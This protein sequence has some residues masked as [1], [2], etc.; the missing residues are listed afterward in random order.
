MGGDIHIIW[1]L[2]CFCGQIQFHYVVLSL[3]TDQMPSLSVALPSRTDQ[4][5]SPS[6]VLP[7]RT[8]H[9][10][11]LSVIILSLQST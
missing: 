8:V 7:S 11:F 6:V 3:R 5:P 2:L 4:M 9:M 10:L 1:V